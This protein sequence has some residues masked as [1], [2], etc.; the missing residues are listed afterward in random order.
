MISNKI[1]KID[2]IK[3]DTEG[4]ELNVLKSLEKKIQNIKII[5]FE[6]HF[7][8]MII[9]N[10]NLTDIHNYLTENGF[11]KFFKVKMKFRK[12]FE[13]LYVNKNFSI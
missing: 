12:S 1:D 11:A 4:Y 7:D 10:Y 8:D 5:H 6:H 3:I 9:K 2:L 13:Y